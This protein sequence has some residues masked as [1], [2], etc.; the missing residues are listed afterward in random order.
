L[1]NS[2]ALIGLG[3]VMFMDD[4]L[5]IY[6]AEYIKQNYETPLNLCVLDGGGLGF[7]LMTYFQE[8]AKVIIISTTSVDGK[9][10][11]I[12][13]F[14]KDELMSQGSTRSS[15]NEVEAVMMLEICSILDDEMADVSIVSMKPHDIIP[16]KT[17]LTNE[18]QEKF[19]DFIELIL[20][21]LKT[22]GIKLEPKKE[23][24]SLQEI[25]DNFSNPTQSIH[26]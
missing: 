6:A 19:P 24:V 20:D 2:C 22:S 14:T 26:I 21:S 12:F 9:S 3:N 1:N 8:Y 16:V 7:T 4:G 13:S 15:A 11:D 5:G 17:D 10:G 25:L 23:L 18:V